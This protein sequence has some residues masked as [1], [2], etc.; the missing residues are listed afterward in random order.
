MQC[1]HGQWQ[2]ACELS[3]TPGSGPRRH[4]LVFVVMSSVVYVEMD[5]RCAPLHKV[6][7]GLDRRTGSNIYVTFLVSKEKMARV[8][9]R[10]LLDGIAGPPPQNTPRIPPEYRTTLPQA[11]SRAPASPSP[12]DQHSRPIQHAGRRQLPRD[13][14][15]RLDQPRAESTDFIKPANMLTCPL[16]SDSNS[17]SSSAQPVFCVRLTLQYLTGT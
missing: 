10:S 1:T 15:D 16:K 3:T 2:D 6:H 14:A 7:T 11:L 13:G 8:T 5:R 12:R 17:N 9:S 4:W